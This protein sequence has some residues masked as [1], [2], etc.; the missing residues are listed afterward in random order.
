[1]AMPRAKHFWPRR[2]INRMGIIDRTEPGMIIAY[3]ASYWPTKSA[4]LTALPGGCGRIDGAHPRLVGDPVL[5]VH[6]GH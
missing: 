4:E 3:S 6:G 2:K 5:C 1:V